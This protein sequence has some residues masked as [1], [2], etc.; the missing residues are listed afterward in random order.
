[1]TYKYHEVTY[2]VILNQY[3][4]YDV[5][6]SNSVGDIKQNHCTLK[7]ILSQFENK[8]LAEAGARG[9]G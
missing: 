6:P 9:R 7:Y 8:S 4:K 5:N 3:P 1:M 2:S